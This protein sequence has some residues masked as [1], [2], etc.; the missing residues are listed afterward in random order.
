MKIREVERIIKIENEHWVGNGFKVKQYF[1]RGVGNDFLNRFSP[2]LMMDYNKPFKFKGSNND[3]GVG[4]HPHKG[5]ETVTFSFEGEIEHTDSEKNNGIIKAGD[6]QWMT[7]GKGILHKEYHGK[8]YAKNDRILHSIQLWVNLPKKYKLTDPKYQ[9]ITSEEMGNYT[10]DG[11]NAVV[12]SGSFKNVNGP[13]STFTPINIYKISIEEGK[14]ISIDEPIGFNT[15]FL[16]INGNVK[17][18]SNINAI[19]EDFV[20]LTNEGEYFELEAI[21]GEA[22][23]FL[24]SGEPINEPIVAAGPFVMNTYDEILEAFD[25]YKNG[26]F[27]DENF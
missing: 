25:D 1:P 15:G 9:S 4:V 19:R 21:D 10:E 22:D 18:N 23:I 2:F 27:G 3:F 20:L 16:V 5:F 26:K 7:A 12:Y 11:I 13:A 6:I 24:L 14:K 17:I 8:E